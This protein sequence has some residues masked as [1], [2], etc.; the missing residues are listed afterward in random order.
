[1]LREEQACLSNSVTMNSYHGF[2][3][4]LS[5]ELIMLVIDFPFTKKQNQITWTVQARV[6]IGLLITWRFEHNNSASR[7]FY[8]LAVL[9]HVS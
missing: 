7:K 2:K 5:M 6:V 9:H 4:P 8:T 3:K 1:M